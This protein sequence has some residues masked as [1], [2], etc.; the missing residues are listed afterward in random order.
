[1]SLSNS[2]RPANWKS[3]PPL[4]TG[5]PN[6]TFAAQSSLPSLPVPELSDTLETLKTTLKPFARNETELTAVTDKIDSFA[7]KEGPKLQE[8]LVQRARETD[9][10][11]EAW[12]DD[13][14]YMSYRDSVRD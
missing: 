12:W 2:N 5:T 10:W 7:A 3:A 4:P 13:A 6:L 1:M 9:H 14:G 8:L 11:L